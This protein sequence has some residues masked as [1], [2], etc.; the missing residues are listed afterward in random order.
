[1]TQQA[2]LQEKVQ[3]LANLHTV[4]LN[5]VGIGMDELFSTM[6]DDERRAILPGYMILMQHLLAKFTDALS[7]KPPAT[8]ESAPKEEPPMITGGEMVIKKKTKK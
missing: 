4:L 7:V 8:E 6:K 3:S 1:M 5:A 2:T